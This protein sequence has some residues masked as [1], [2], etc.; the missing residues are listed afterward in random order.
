MK[1]KHLK[2]LCIHLA[3]IALLLAGST[4][5]L[6][7]SKA[8]STPREG[9]VLVDLSRFK[10]YRSVFTQ[11]EVEQSLFGQPVSA[12]R[13]GEYRIGIRIDDGSDYHAVLSVYRAMD[14]KYVKV[15][16]CPALIGKTAPESRPRETARHR[17][18][19]GPSAGPTA[20][21]PTREQASPIP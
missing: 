3:A 18:A 7:V 8:N 21:P 6:A 17:S 4:V 12:E 11:D 5:W 20:L 1:E 9:T 19:P 14:G 2:L 16:T 15:Y 13:S 10:V